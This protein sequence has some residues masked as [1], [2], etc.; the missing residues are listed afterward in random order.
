MLCYVNVNV[1]QTKGKCGVATLS[2][3]MQMVLKKT[4]T[5][6]VRFSFIF[7]QIIAIATP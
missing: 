7:L 2:P 4:Q 5:W 3:V 6:R 1:H